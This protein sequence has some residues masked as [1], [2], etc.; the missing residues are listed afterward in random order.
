[1]GQAFIKG[2]Q[3]LFL[4]TKAAV[5]KRVSLLIRGAKH[6]DWGADLGAS[7]AFIAG[8][9]LTGH[10]T[11]TYISFAPYESFAHLSAGVP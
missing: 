6:V 4:S 1:M 11:I 2:G 8:V 7:S 5:F 9:M 3:S 10:L